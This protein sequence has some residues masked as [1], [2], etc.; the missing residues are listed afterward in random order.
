MQMQRAE[1]N[2]REY[3]VENTVVNIIKIANFI[4]EVIAHRKIMEH[5]IRMD[6]LLLK[7]VLDVSLR[8][9]L[10]LS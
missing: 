3:I 2:I 9:L 5:D 10:T 4:K 1:K 6:K 7:M 8:V